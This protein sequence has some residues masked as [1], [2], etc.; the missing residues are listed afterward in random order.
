MQ[1]TALS[2]LERIRISPEDEAAWARLDDLYRPLLTSWISRDASIRQWTDDIVQEVMTALIKELPTFQRERKG[3]FRKWL[4]TIAVHRI[5]NFVRQKRVFG[6]ITLK[7]SDLDRFF[8]QSFL[9]TRA[10]AQDLDGT[11]PRT[12]RT[13][14]IRV[15]NHPRRSAQVSRRDLFDKARDVNMRRTSMCARRVVTVKTPIRFLQSF[16]PC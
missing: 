7:S 14:R 3:S 8:D 13:D 2:L 6:R 9:D 4:R 12:R 5:L 10:F 11:N 1:T 15:K 16:R